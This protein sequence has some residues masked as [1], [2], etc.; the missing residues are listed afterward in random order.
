MKQS[1]I[2]RQSRL[3]HP[4]LI[5]LLGSF[6]LGG[7]IYRLQIPQGNILDVEDIERLE[8]GM[9]KVQVEYLLGAPGLA[10]T[11]NAQRWDYVY[12]IIT[13]KN[14]LIYKKG[15]LL[16]N[17]DKLAAIHMNDFLSEP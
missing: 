3:Y 9:T 11:L 1:I 2:Y 17:G 4:F 15:Y 14:K 10:T 13:R 5:L 16:F 6:L 7:C 8:F 12:R